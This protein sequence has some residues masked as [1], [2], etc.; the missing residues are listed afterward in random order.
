MLR[1]I[2]RDEI[3]HKIKIATNQKQCDEYEEPESLGYYF[4]ECCKTNFLHQ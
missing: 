3:F 2:T 4:F 1:S